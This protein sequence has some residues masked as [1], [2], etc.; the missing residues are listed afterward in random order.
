MRNQLSHGVTLLELLVSVSAIAIVT[1]L[2]AQVFFTTTRVNRRNVTAQE[3]KANGDLAL[4][5]MER[6]ARN[7]RALAFTCDLGESTTPSAAFVN[8]D[9]YTSRITCLSDGTSARVAS[10]SADGTIYYLTGSTL[11]ISATGD[12][13]CA[14]STL[15]F[16]CDALSGTGPLSMEFTLRTL[17]SYDPTGSTSATFATSVQSRNSK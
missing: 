13:T 9:L 12:K 15:T 1:I 10:V 3:I 16:S 4:N 7:S 14:D 11:T 6:M 8:P 17:G 2:I 5:V